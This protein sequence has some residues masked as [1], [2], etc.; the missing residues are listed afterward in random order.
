MITFGYN[1]QQQKLNNDVANANRDQLL[2]SEKIKTQ[3]AYDEH[4]HRH[5][6][7]K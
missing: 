3:G 5:D 2:I 7:S 6:D 4:Q 1:V